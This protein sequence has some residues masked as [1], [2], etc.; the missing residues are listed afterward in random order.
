MTLSSLDVTRAQIKTLETETVVRAAWMYYEEGMTQEEIAKRLGISRVKVTRLNKQARE[1]GIVK[2]KI[3]TPMAQF[4]KLEQG[5]RQKFNLVDVYVTIETG[6]GEPLYRVLANAAASVL[7]QRLTP[8]LVIGMGFGQTTSF[9]PDYFHPEK[10][11]HCTFIVLTGGLPTTFQNQEYASPVERLARQAGSKFYYLN[12][13]LIASEAGIKE[14]ILSDPLIFDAIKLARRSDIA[15]F[16][17]GTASDSALLYQRGIMDEHDF[18]EIR[19]RGGVGDALGHFYDEL[20]RELPIKFNQR[21]IG[22]NLDELRTVP[23]RILVAGGSYKYHAITGALR[24]RIANILVT[25][26][27]TARWLIEEGEA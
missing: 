27:K 6:E 23:L 5:L 2:I 3:Q 4:L 18:E 22:L 14:A 9:L 15:L 26:A 20:G 21:L 24:G 25:D 16:S 19:Q 17:V 12:A 10:E 1:L 8:G 7:E 11:I 13:P